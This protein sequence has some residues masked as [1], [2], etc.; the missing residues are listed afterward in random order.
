MRIGLGVPEIIDCND[1]KFAAALAFIQGP[2]HVAANSAISVNRDFDGHT[3][4][5]W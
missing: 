2:E 4:L 3:W 1:F 5:L